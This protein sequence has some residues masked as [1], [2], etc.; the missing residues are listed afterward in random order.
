M[1]RGTLSAP[2][3]S[4]I[5]VQ[6]TLTVTKAGISPDAAADSYSFYNQQSAHLD[7]EFVNDCSQSMDSLLVF[8]SRSE[9]L[10][11]T[12]QFLF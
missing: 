2:E 1:N 9:T 12:N 5:P 3:N 10:L 7:N 4:E 6:D 8:V 11:E